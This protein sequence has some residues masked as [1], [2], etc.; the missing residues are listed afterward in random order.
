MLAN[1]NP[2]QFLA[3]ATVVAARYP[4]AELVKNPVGNLSV[5]VDGEYVA[6][7]DLRTGE[8]AEVG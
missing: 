5:V 1:M 6:Y 8:V 3:A 4:T 7:V 2:Q